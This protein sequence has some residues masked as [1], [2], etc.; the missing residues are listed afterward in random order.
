M[1][2]TVSAATAVDL[3]PARNRM[4]WGDQTQFA[5]PDYEDFRI[6]KAHGETPVGHAWGKDRMHFQW[7]RL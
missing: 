1:I 4:R 7:A 6:A 5:G 2:S 3:I